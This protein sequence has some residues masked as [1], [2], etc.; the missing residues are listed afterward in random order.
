MKINR[1]DLMEY[2]IVERCESGYGFYNEGKIIERVKIWM[3]EGL[4][5]TIPKEEWQE[6]GWIFTKKGKQYTKL[7]LKK[8]RKRHGHDWVTY[9]GSDIPDPFAYSIGTHNGFECRKCGYTFC[10]HC[11]VEF[12]IEKC[13]KT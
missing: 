11:K 13:N 4:M 8:L 1:F 2:K 9:E 10:Q 7:F 5:K 3:K 6:K 12:E